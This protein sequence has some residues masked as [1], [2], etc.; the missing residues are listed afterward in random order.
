MQNCCLSA[1]TDESQEGEYEVESI[2]D[3]QWDVKSKRWFYLVQW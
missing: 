2:L 3:H 1:Y